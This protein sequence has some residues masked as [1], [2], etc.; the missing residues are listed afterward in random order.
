MRETFRKTQFRNTFYEKLRS[1]L[2]YRVLFVRFK[3][4]FNIR[5]I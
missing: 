5:V 4:S 1:F 3:Y 2:T